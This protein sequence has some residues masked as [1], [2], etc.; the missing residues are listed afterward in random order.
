M[1]QNLLKNKKTILSTQG[2]RGTRDFYPEAQRIKN[3]VNSKIHQLLKSY[4]YE[5]YSGPFVEHLELYAAKSSEEI[6]KDQLYSFQDKGERKLAIRPEMTPTLARMIASKQKE[7]LKPI[8]WYS[9]PTCMRFERPQRGR[10]REFDQLN[11]D[12][13]GGNA[14]DEDVE[15]IMTAIDILRSLGGQYSDFQVKINHRGIINQFLANIIKISQDN[16]SP[17]LRLFDKKDKLSESDFNQQCQNLNLNDKQIKSINTFLQASIDEVI[18]LLGPYAQSAQDLKQRLDILTTLTSSECIKFAPDIMRGFDYY[19]GMVFEVFDTHPDN[20]RAL[21][22]GGR[23][24]NLVGAF[25]GD[26][27]PGVGYGVGDVSL[28]NFMEVHGLLPRL[29]KE[30]HVCVLRFSQTD[31]LMALQLAKQLRARNL[32]VETSITESK[33]GKQIQNAEKLGA[34]AVAFVGQEEMEKN[35]FSVKWLHSGQ[36]ETF[37]N[38]AEGYSNFKEKLMSFI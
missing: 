15:I 36:Q 26:E 30:T 1:A 3:F 14:L 19:T 33:F 6:V 10:L 35:A 32:N 34:K 28:T 16:I 2:Y 7:L 31:R 18:D 37:T 22:G 27:L 5:E 38:N 4:G 29:F 21:F 23:Y 17:I 12:L 13:F 24:D 9:I 8:R 20:H 11:V 25:G